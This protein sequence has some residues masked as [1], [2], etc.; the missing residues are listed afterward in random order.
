M[1]MEGV[2]EGGSDLNNIELSNKQWGGGS[3]EEEG[4]L[5]EEQ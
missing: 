5:R 2:E 3:S 4:G 1:G